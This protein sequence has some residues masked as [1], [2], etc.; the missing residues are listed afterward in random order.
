MDTVVENGNQSLCRVVETSATVCFH[1]TTLPIRLRDY[2][3]ERGRKSINNRGFAVRL[4]LLGLSENINKVPPT[5]LPKYELN[6]DKNH[7]HSNV[8]GLF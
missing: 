5:Q 1:S 3:E 6:K 8:G 7:R 2:C 4:C